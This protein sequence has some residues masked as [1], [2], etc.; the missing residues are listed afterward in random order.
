M[1]WT[2]LCTG[3][4]MTTSIPSIRFPLGNVV[5]TH[6]ADQLLR[7][8]NHSP[9]WYLARHQCG[10][11]GDVSPDD[12]QANEAALMHGAR[13]VSAYLTGNALLW[14]ITEADRSSTT[15]LLPSEY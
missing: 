3:T 8:L 2:P 11:W 10:D 5:A 12:G 6:G 4:I 1:P 15:L 7:E 14:V 13:L 9:L